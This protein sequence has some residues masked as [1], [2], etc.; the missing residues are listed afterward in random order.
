MRFSATSVEIL[1]ADL[2][3]AVPVPPSTATT[4]EPLPFRSR[5]ELRDASRSRTRTRPARSSRTSTWSIE[6]RTSVALVGATGSGKTT[7]ID[8]LLGLLT[9][10][11]G[12]CVVDG[13][14][15]T[16]TTSGVAEEP[17]LRPAAHLPRRRHRRGQHRVRRPGRSAIDRAAVEAAARKANIHD[18]IVEEMPKGYDTEIGERG[19]RLSGG[20]RQR[21]GIARALYTTPTSSSST[22]RRAR[23]TT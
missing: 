8:L 18:F 17:R 12:S 21:L 7:A 13:V 4:I 3:R 19:M 11:A 5:L 16:R 14:A 23:S 6:A 22:R 10:Q 2:E 15:V 9:P 20:Q 1:H